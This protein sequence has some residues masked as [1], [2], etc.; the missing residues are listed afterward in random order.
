M[1]WAGTGSK[2]EQK[3]VSPGRC[4]HLENVLALRKG[5]TSPAEPE[6]GML[7]QGLGRKKNP[8]EKEVKRGKSRRN[9]Q[10]D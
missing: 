1:H 9:S 2:R 7:V 6:P 10:C 4:C 8:L 3:M 5:S